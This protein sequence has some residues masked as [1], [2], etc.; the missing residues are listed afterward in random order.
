M[1]PSFTP[2]IAAAAAEP[3][4]RRSQD[5]SWAAVAAG[6]RGTESASTF[7]FTPP[8][9]VAIPSLPATSPNNAISAELQA[10]RLSSET[11]TNPAIR[12]IL[13]S[14]GPLRPLDPRT[15]NLQPPLELFAIGVSPTST[16]TDT[17]QDPSALHSLLRLSSQSAGKNL[18]PD[19]II[20]GLGRWTYIYYPTSATDSLLQ[21]LAHARLLLPTLSTTETRL[22]YMA[23]KLNRSAALGVSLRLRRESHMIANP[24]TNTQVAWRFRR[25]AAA[26]LIADTKRIADHIKPTPQPSV[27]I[28][29]TQAPVSTPLRG[30]KPMHI[31]PPP[32]PSP[33]P[34]NGGKKISEQ[35]RT[36][37]TP[38][39]NDGNP[40]CSQP[41]RMNMKGSTNEPT[42]NRCNENSTERLTGS[43][44]SQTVK[45]AT[46]RPH[47]PSTHF[48]PPYQRQCAPQPTPV[49][50]DDTDD[51]RDTNTASDPVP[52]K[53]A[54]TPASQTTPSQERQ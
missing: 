16:P 50:A 28:S 4:H 33:N 46:K 5:H 52:L 53:D 37:S 13:S 19:V 6:R 2:S 38:I 51:H 9:S 42:P 10:A 45:P 44:G 36:L 34:P 11:V 20:P 3:R 14:I 21:I 35:S 32:S 43:N 12:S 41:Q 24:R 49:L 22:I 18:P 48:S 26:L 54:S 7:T 40:T 23:K 39:R 47:S 29:E 8:A 31:T 25:A 1:H 15:G 27:P 30:P 17:F